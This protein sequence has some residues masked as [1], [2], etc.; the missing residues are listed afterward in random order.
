VSD[1]ALDGGSRG[2]GSRFDALISDMNDSGTRG[3]VSVPTNWL[4]QQLV[5]PSGH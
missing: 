2:A 4:V 3:P 5:L 1:G